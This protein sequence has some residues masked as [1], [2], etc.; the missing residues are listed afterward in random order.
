MHS[1]QTRK[2]RF[3]INQTAS[4]LDDLPLPSAGNIYEMRCDCLEDNGGDYRLVYCGCQGCLQYNIQ[5]LEQMM[6]EKY[7]GKHFSQ[8]WGKIYLKHLGS[9]TPPP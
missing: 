4:R 8:C 3:I 7:R 9:L 2:A 5:A 6:R 1:Q